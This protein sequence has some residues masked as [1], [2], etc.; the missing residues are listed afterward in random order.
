[1]P[2]Y[3]FRVTGDRQPQEL[4]EGIDLKDRDAVWKEATESLG[5][6]IRD[7]DGALPIDG[8]WSMEVS[9][10]NGPLFV[11]SVNVEFCR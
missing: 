11:I 1:M 9:D 7:I 2:R 8:N 10:E 3:F 4:E 5:E 6:M